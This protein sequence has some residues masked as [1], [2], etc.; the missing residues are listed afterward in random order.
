MTIVKIILLVLRIDFYNFQQSA[1]E[2]RR[3]RKEYIEN[4]E[5]RYVNLK[6]VFV[7]FKE[8]PGTDKG[9]K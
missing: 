2:S 7:L 8:K 6:N 3:R 9:S 1:M 5:K 4:L